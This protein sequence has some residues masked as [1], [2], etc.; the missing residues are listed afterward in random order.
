MHRTKVGSQRHVCKPT[1]PKPTILVVEDERFVG[2]VT[3][4]ILRGAGYRVLQVECVSA[5]RAMFQPGKN[6]KSIQ[7]VFC[8][9]V[10]PDGSGIQLSQTLRK[11]SPKLKVVLASGYPEAG[12]R[13]ASVGPASSMEFLAKPYGAIAL[14]S[15]V[16][17]ALQGAA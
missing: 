2:N 8:D 11:V 14:I 9:A 1:S 16:K 3:C 4:Q 5:A 15:K 6:R 17:A 7:L 10:L 13:G 12:P